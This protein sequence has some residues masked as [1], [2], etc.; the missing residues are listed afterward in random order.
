[1]PSESGIVPTENVKEEKDLGVM[2]DSKLN[3]REDSVKRI[4]CDQFVNIFHTLYHFA[5]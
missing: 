1:M 2:I 3:F 5:P 4:P